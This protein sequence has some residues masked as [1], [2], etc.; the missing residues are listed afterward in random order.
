MTGDLLSSFAHSGSRGSLAFDESDG[1]L[2][3]VPNI[4]SSNLL[5]YSTAGALL[6][7]L[8]TPTRVGNVWGAEISISGAPP[9]PAPASIFLMGLGLVAL[10]FRLRRS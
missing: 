6:T 10:G 2:W 3:Y 7:S 5:Q 1:T 8:S 4:A 9:V